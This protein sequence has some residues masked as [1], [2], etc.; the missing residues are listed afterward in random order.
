MWF[1][2][3]VG[4]QI[5][6]NRD[7][8]LTIKAFGLQ[9]AMPLMAAMEWLQVR[10][11]DP[12]VVRTLLSNAFVKKRVMW[13]PL[14]LENASF[15]QTSLDHLEPVLRDSAKHFTGGRSQADKVL[16]AY[17]EHWANSVHLCAKAVRDGV[18]AE[19]DPAN[20]GMDMDARDFYLG[21]I[22]YMRLNAY[23]AVTMLLN[24]LPPDDLVRCHAV[25]QLTA[26]IT[27]LRQYAG[28]YE[29]SEEKMKQVGFFPG[30][31]YQVSENFGLPPDLTL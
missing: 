14:H 19:R 8:N 21:P 24:A 20:T 15:V 5:Q 16:G 17:L 23:P 1:G 10:S 28:R 25:G 13:Q 27:D 31:A 29:F 7:G 30:T 9:L 3:A 11:T 12:E 22:G 6:M 2:D 26:G 18:D 4:L